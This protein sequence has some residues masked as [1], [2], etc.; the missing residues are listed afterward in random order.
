M[1][2]LLGG[3]LSFLLGLSILGGLSCGSDA[4]QPKQPG[5]GG[6]ASTDGSSH[7]PASDSGPHADAGKDGPG[8]GMDAANT[9]D[10]TA[11]S[12][13]AVVPIDDCMAK[14]GSVAWVASIP[15]TSSTLILSDVAVGPTNDVIVSDQSG[16]T[17]EQHRWDESG[18]VVSLHQDSLGAYAGKLWTSNLVIDGNNDLFY[19]MLMTGLPQGSNSGAELVFTKLPPTGSAVFTDTVLGAMPTSSGPPKVL[20]FDAGYDTGGNLHGALSMATPNAFPPGVYCYAGNGANLGTSAGSVTGT[21]TASDYE[22]PTQDEGLFLLEPVSADIDLGCGKV[23]VPAS[24]GVVLAKLD[25]GGDCQWNTFL[26]LPKAAVKGLTFRLGADTSVAIGVV[27][28][29]TINFGGGALT[30]KGS[31]SLA[32]ARFD[33]TGKLLFTKNFGG[34]G[35]SFEVGSLAV[36]PDGTL[37]VTAGYEG[38]VD[39][40]GGALPAAHDTFVAVFDQAGAF[41]WNQSVTVGAEG[42]LKAAAG[43]CGVVVTTNSPSVDF[44]TG[45][46]S[47]KG[48]TA[49]SIGLAALGL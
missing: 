36:N 33:V 45:A 47:M 14:S 21:L 34:A 46:L 29:G 42:S 24:G 9:G 26:S 15:V 19:G 3:P 13:I 48:A 11:D 18:T 8:V 44:G 40:G 23:P 35:S 2:Y 30:S 10:S 22:F 43:K 17:Y 5:E 38:T 37:L 16:A 32:L 6:D 1:R 49:N 20:L 27:Y 39:L 4:A 31:D 25:G 7:P 28:S 12:P 41:K